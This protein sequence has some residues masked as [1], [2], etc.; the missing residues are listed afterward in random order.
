MRRYALA[1]LITLLCCASASAQ[2][3]TPNASFDANPLVVPGI[4]AL[5][6]ASGNAVGTLQTVRAF[7]NV[8]TPSGIVNNLAMSWR[9]VET[10]ALTYYVFDTLPTATTCTDRAAFVLGSVDVPK[11]IM[12]PFTLTAAAPSVGTTATF[13]NSSFTPLSVNNKDTPALT[14]NLYVCGVAGGAFTPAVGDLGYKI[15]VVQD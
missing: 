1:L 4:Q 11:L 2:Q 5:A 13:A 6:Y 8:Q 10:I 3:K 7:R 15:S 9:G 14:P 12:P